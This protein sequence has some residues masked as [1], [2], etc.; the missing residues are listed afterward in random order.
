[1]EDEDRRAHLE[2]RVAVLERIVNRLLRS[3]RDSHSGAAKASHKLRTT[4]A[5]VHALEK[6]DRAMDAT[7]IS[8]IASGLAGR[9][10]STQAVRQSLPSCIKNKQVIRVARG[11]YRLAEARNG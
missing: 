4:E 3:G 8:F 6:T 2:R 11:K 1:M 9:E 5:I 10:V 7:E